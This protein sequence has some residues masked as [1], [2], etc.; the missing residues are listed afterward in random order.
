MVLERA[1][2]GIEAFTEWYWN[3]H[4][5]VL[6][7]A[8]NGIEVCRLVLRRAQ[9]GMEAFTAWHGRAQTGIM[10]CTD[11]FYGVLRLQCL[12]V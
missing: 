2:T 4:R 12:S 8:L 3:V 1:Q 5:L 10:A 6:R 9:T 11:W 7:R